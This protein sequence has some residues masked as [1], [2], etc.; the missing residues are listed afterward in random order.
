MAHRNAQ[1]QQFRVGQLW[2]PAH[3]RWF[4]QPVIDLHVKCG[5]KGVQVCLHKLILNT[6]HPCP[7]TAPVRTY[8][9]RRT[10]GGTA[11]RRARWS[12]GTRLS[13]GVRWRRGDG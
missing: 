8:S 11:V 3:P 10:G 2:W 1:G 7:D 12:G 5:E 4:A 9:S 13:R 6:R